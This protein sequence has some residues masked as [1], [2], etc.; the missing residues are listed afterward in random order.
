VTAAPSQPPRLKRYEL[1]G[2][3]LHVWTP[4]KGVE[5]P[6]VPV[7]R[8]LI[9]GAVVAVVLG[10][11]A[12]VIVPAIDKGKRRGA[13]E[14][15]RAEQAYVAREK[16]RLA[17]DQTPRSG[18]STTRTATDAGTRALVLADMRAAITSDARARARAGTI[19]GPISRTTCDVVPS[20]TNAQRGIY[21]CLAVSG[22]EDNSVKGFSLLTGY[23]FIANVDFTHG[24][25]VWCKLNPRPGE[26]ARG[27]IPHVQVSPACAGKLSEAL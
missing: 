18:R 2:A 24:S 1:V 8:L 11:A 4:P 20:L 6:P 25:F 16:A 12:A 23:S 22:S 21:R 5:V 3:W 26:R 19:D 7:R 10:G 15:A 9:W 14:R 17:K 27:D 13:A